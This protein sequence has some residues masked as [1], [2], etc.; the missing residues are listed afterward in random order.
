MPAANQ[1]CLPCASRFQ[2]SW[3]LGRIAEVNDPYRAVRLRAPVR[4]LTLGSCCNPTSNAVLQA[5]LS[6]AFFSLR[7]TV[8]SSALGMNALQSL[9][10]SGVHAMRCSNV[11]CAKEG[12]GEMIADS[13]ASDTRHFVRGAGRSRGRSFRLSTFIG[14]S[15]I[16]NRSRY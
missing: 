8:M 11:P 3:W 15:A 7:Q 14:E 16:R 5:S 10:T 13:N 6:S 1:A 9:S 4:S 12:A 2:E